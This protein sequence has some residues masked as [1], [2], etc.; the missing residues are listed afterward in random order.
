MAAFPDASSETVRRAWSLAV[1][2]E[3]AV[4]E[5]ADQLGRSPKGVLLFA[6]PRY[7]LDKLGP[8]I[9]RAFD[10]PVIGCTTAGEFCS[11]AGFLTGSLVAAGFYTEELEFVPWFIPSLLDYLRNPSPPPPHPRDGLPEVSGFALLFVD[12][13]SF[14]EERLAALLYRMLGP[15][16][17]LTGA[18]AGD[19]WAMRNT[20]VYWDG[21]FHSGAGVTGIFATSLPFKRFQ[22]HHFEPT[23]IKVVITDA[24]ADCRRVREING[25]PAAAEYARIVGVPVE[26]LTLDVFAAFPLLLKIGGQSHIRSIARADADGSLFFYSAV[27][28]GLVLSLG[29][30]KKMPRH[31]NQQLENL[32]AELPGLQFVLGCDCA[33]RRL[34]A[35]RESLVEEME[36]VLS[37]YPVLGFSTYGEIH[38]GMHLNQTFAGIAIGGAA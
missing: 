12:G 23:E 1:S 21:K 38:G 33:L 15:R 9:K 2:P 20:W 24:D 8:A 18:A 7:D 16:R 25:R 4:A 14:I 29:R 28:N 10:C 5:I 11:P 27:E 32:A 6:S 17:G 36:N 13:L 3:R 37:R 35:Q 26:E 34:E 30:A 31:L 19:D 22:F